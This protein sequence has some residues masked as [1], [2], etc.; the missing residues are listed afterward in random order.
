MKID[1]HRKTEWLYGDFTPEPLP[2]EIAKKRLDAL[3][4]HLTKLLD[5]GF[6]ER[7]DQRI[8]DVLKAIDF[9]ERW[10]RGIYQ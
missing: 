4:K 7:D 10:E 1:E 2:K 8:R 3:N 9:W 5:R 6:W